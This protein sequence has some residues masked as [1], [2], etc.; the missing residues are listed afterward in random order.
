M[1]RVLTT[2]AAVAALVLVAKVVGLPGKTVAETQMTQSPTQ[3][4]MSI[5]DMHV[6]Q[7][8]MRNVRPDQ[9]PAP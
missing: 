2:L 7:S 5:Y 6:G 4:A 3:N 8:G 1:R 9:I